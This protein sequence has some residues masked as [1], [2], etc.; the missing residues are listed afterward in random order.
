MITAQQIDPNAGIR[1]TQIQGGGLAMGGL[2]MLGP[3]GRVLWVDSNA[4]SK[5]DGRANGPFPTLKLAYSQCESGRGDVI[6]IAAGHTESVIAAG[7]ITMSKNDVSV[8][9]LGRAQR[10]PT[11]TFSTVVG[12]SILLS[13]ASN[14]LHNLRFN[15]QGIDALTQPIDVTGTDNQVSGCA[16]IG[17]NASAQPTNIVN[18][19]ST[20]DWTRILGNTFLAN[21]D[22]A[23]V[24]A[25]IKVVGTNGV[26][27]A[28]NYF[29]GAY[30]SGKGAIENVTTACT[31]ARILRNT[32]HNRT[33]S[34][35]KAMVFVSTST[36]VIG[37][38]LMQILSG[39]A[40]ITGAAMSWVGG[41]YYA[42]AV[43]TAGTLI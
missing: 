9:G 19:Q 3:R 14:L 25:A 16:F 29:S 32:I 21:T 36:G 43:A 5:S 38:N 34:S 4:P 24:D 8:I 13:G 37:Q 20:A 23:G 27:I 18:V 7:G 22:D 2:P 40:P 12:A 1:L 15:C 42:N 28:D 39:T 41:N 6:L 11:I 10:R 30:N 31:R 26:E 35:T 33:A 17:G